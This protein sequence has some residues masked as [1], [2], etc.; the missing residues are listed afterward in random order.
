MLPSVASSSASSSYTTYSGEANLEAFDGEGAN[1]ALPVL[2]Q[3]VIDLDDVGT[4][5]RDRKLQAILRLKQGLDPF[6]KYPSGAEPIP[7][8]HNPDTWAALWPVLF[9]FGIGT[10][11]DPIRTE[12]SFG[13]RPLPLK[14]HIKKLLSLH[15]RRFCTHPSFIFVM[16]NI[17]QRRASSFS[18]TLATR[19]AWFDDV[20]KDVQALSTETVQ[21]LREKVEKTSTYQ[22]VSDQETAC[23][24][25]LRK[26]QYLS[27][28]V[29]GS[30]GEIAAYR[31]EIR[32]TCRVKGVP[33]LYIT[34]NPADTH[35]P[36][37]QFFAG[38]DV[39]LPAVV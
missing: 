35:H 37:A 33:H 1:G 27:Q 13:L 5:Y 21:A 4:T 15:D 38:R 2:S 39:V 11:E 7:T 23:F 28:P 3:G 12:T 8:A 14:T 6:I 9:P 32:A 20:A 29:S 36:V 30:S 34:L 25:V 26:L 16:M 18:A 24:R 10:F 31:E 22:P 17:L 19:R